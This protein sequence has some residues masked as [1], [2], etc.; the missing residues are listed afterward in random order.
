[1]SIEVQNLLTE[2]VRKFGASDGSADFQQVFTDAVN[3]ALGDIDNRLL[4]STTAIDPASQTIDLDEQRYK[5]CLSALVDYYI[6]VQGQWSLKNSEELY[7][8]GQRKLVDLQTRYI[9]TLDLGVRFG[10]LSE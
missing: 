10:D 9:Q 1:M 7:R 8:M 4:I 6:S 5:P 2:K 3:Y